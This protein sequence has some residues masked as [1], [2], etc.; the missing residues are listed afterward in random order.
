MY[1]LGIRSWI[2]IVIIIVGYAGIP[3][4]YCIGKLEIVWNITEISCMEVITMYSSFV[5][6]PLSALDIFLL[7][8]EKME[9]KSSLIEFS[10]ILYD[11]FKKNHFQQLYSSE[12]RS[13]QSTTN[14]LIEFRK[15]IFL[16]K[17]FLYLHLM[18]QNQNNLI[19]MNIDF[20]EKKLFYDVV[21]SGNSESF[22]VVSI[23]KQNNYNYMCRVEFTNQ[24]SVNTYGCFKLANGLDRS[25]I[26]CAKYEGESGLPAKVYDYKYWGLK[27]RKI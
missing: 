19:Q 6:L 22:L 5:S 10:D 1:K 2:F 8:K 27:K 12:E 20:G 18:N 11:D 13:N 15:N 3:L 24:Y 26:A 25:D 23:P 9:L 17:R 14:E 7:S 16:E 4:I 21:V